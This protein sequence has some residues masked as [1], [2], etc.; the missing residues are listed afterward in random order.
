MIG[1]AENE[2]CWLEAH[3]WITCQEQIMIGGPDVATLHF[4][5][6][7]RISILSLHFSLNLSERHRRFLVMSGIIG[8]VA[9][10]RT[11]PGS[12]LTPTA[13]EFPLIPR[14]DAQRIWTNHNAGFGHT[15]FKTT[16][17]S[18]ATASL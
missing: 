13:Y 8:V 18:E 7:S 4:A 6:E 1:V 14:S 15:L 11:A 10:R 2:A 5:S 9:I 12:R 16:D 17:E 3:A